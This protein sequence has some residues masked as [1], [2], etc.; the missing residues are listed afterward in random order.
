MFWF[1]SSSTYV[2]IGIFLTE[3]SSYLSFPRFTEILFNL[4]AIYTTDFAITS[5]SK[6]LLMSPW[7]IMRRQYQPKKKVIAFMKKE[8]RKR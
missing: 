8:K 1:L 7:E 2:K 4:P 3:V 6:P 5:K